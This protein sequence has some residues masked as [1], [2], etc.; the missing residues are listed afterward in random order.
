MSDSQNV[1]G[2]A[3]SARLSYEHAKDAATQVVGEVRERAADYMAKGKE[4]AKC[5]QGGTEEF[6]RENPVKS[7]LIA[8]GAGVLLG[9]LIRKL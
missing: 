6:I 2:A 5:L 7:I 9:F 8:A 1:Q 3:Q 4:K